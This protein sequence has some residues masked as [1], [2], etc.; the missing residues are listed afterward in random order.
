M[1][2]EKAF[3]HSLALT[4]KSISLGELTRVW[5]FA[6]V[7][8]GARF[9][10]NCNIASGATID[11]SVFGHD[12]IVCHNVAMGPG[13]VF[14]NGCFVGPNTTIANDSWPRAHRERFNPAEYRDRPAVIVEDGATIGANCVILPGVRIGKN[15]MIAAGAVVSKDV[16]ADM[17]YG[18]SNRMAPIGNEHEKVRMRFAGEIIKP[19]SAADM[20]RAPE[21]SKGVG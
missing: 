5:A 9:G 17:L 7:I 3:I 18:V 16:P 13:F 2:H 20:N 11:G 15:A 6:S 14:G 19:L 21:F 12:C 1:I 4:D 10:R 8:R